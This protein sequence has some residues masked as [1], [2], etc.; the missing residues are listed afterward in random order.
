[1]TET[2]NGDSTAL[3]ASGAKK[4]AKLSFC[5]SNLMLPF[6]KSTFFVPEDAIVSVPKGVNR[7]QNATVL[8]QVINTKS[9]QTWMKY[10]FLG[11]KPAH[12]VTFYQQLVACL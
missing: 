7:V 12:L 8:N 10:A 2:A 11:L 6:G 1:M 3:I 5:K 4:K 9:P